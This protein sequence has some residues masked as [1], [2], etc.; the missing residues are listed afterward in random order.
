MTT[1]LLSYIMFTFIYAFTPGATTA[2]VIRNTLAGGRRRGM[3]ASIGSQTAN[4]I[5]AALALAGVS[6]LL[7]RWPAGLRVLSIAGALFLAWI[8]ITNLRAALFPGSAIGAADGFGGVTGESHPFRE[9]FAINILNP[10]VTS[11][12]VGVAPTFLPNGPTWRALAGLYAIHIVIALTCH[13]FWSSVF[14]RARAFFAG[15]KPRRY[16]DGTV[17]V[18]LLI[19]AWRIAGKF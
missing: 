7:V 16:L 4:L 15:Q 11:F 12:Y 14:H 13:L 9:G 1:Q 10:S 18:I 8:G 17:G 2:V 6:A 3:T 19:L 5:Q